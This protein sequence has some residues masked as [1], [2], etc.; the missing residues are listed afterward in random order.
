MAFVVV[1]F[2]VITKLPLIVEEAVERKP[3]SVVAP[4]RVAPEMVGEV[5]NT[6]AP[7]PVSS[8]RAAIRFADEGVP[9]KVA[10]FA[11]RPE[12]PVAIGR[13]VALV[14]VAADGVPRFGV[15]KAGELANTKAPLPV[16]SVMSVESSEEVSIDEEPSLPWKTDQSA[17]VRK[18]LVE[19]EA[20]WP[21]V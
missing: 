7:V 20:A 16:S 4:V 8:V 17:E 10:T 6:A 18:P 2:P 19:A 1:E 15:V 12:T 11:P 21:L 13:P 5:P 9:R 3:A 14:S